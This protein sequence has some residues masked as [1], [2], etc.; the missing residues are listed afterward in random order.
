MKS[1]GGEP[2]SECSA[3]M[4][5]VD[6]LG[7][8]GIAAA[9]PFVLERHAD[10]LESFFNFCPHSLHKISGLMTSTFHHP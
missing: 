4:S 6:I 7:G 8:H 3:E 2:H 10:D 9:I 5:D 1:G